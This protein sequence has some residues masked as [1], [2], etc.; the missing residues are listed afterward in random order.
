MST[1]GRRAR[2]PGVS[3]STFLA[4]APEVEP[5]ERAA[6]LALA[7]AL[8]TD[9]YV[10]RQQKQARYGIDPVQQLRVLRQRMQ[11]LSTRQF[12]DE[13]TSIFTALRDRHTGYLA[14][15]PYAGRA[16]VLPFLVE[17]CA[18]PGGKPRYVVS[19]LARW[20]RADPDFRP[21]VQL[22]HWNGMPMDRA[23]QR[24]AESQRGANDDARTARGLASLTTRSL[25]HGMPPDD[26][27]VVVTYRAAGGFKEARFEWRVIDAGGQADE[28]RPAV[29]SLIA[30]DPA[31]QTVQR[32]RQQL[33]APGRVADPWLETTKPS[34]FSARPLSARHGYLRIWSFADG[35]DD[36]VLAEACRLVSL[37]PPGGIVVDIRGNPGG[38]VPT[39]ERLLQIFTAGQISP[40]G[41]SLADT[42]VTLAMS[43]A[44]PHEL[45]RW[46]HSLQAAVSTGE[47][48]SQAFPL[49]LHE[50]ANDLAAERRYP[51]PA[52]LIVDPLTYSA[53]DIFAAGFQDN[54]L[55]PVLGTARTTGAGGANVWTGAQIAERTGDLESWPALPSSGAAFTVAVRRATRVGGR[56]G[57]PLEDIGVAV[58]EVHEPTQADL[59]HGN[60]DLLRA[61]VRLLPR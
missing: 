18:G 42:D 57:L 48:Y 58:D 28:N 46:T 17:S 23:V 50:A 56:A 37:L 31:G 39:A 61:A 33:Y 9:V 22:S 27:W 3:L 24:N 6:L 4:R 13:L 21:G 2:P 55:G 1:L 29:G 25:G 38:N 20:C 32:A 7:Q 10:H 14:P 47:P 60:R 19:K 41:F 11:Q 30:H 40:A 35:D 43:R 52:A 53:A 36:G 59:T 16:A 34:V 54:D 26:D 45:G 15:A 5:P 51:G 12:H 44:D 8:L 49:T